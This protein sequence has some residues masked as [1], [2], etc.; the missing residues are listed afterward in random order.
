MQLGKSY[1]ALLSVRRML[2]CVKPLSISNFNGLESR[3]FVP[4]HHSAM[5]VAIVPRCVSMSDI[6]LPI[7]TNLSSIL[8]RE[9]SA[10]R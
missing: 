3:S 2:W 6:N 4:L 5:L 8:E 7:I 1:G 9:A 10:E